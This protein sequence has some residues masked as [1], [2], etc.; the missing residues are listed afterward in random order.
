MSYVYSASL[1]AI[2]TVTA[3]ESISLLQ[4]KEGE[5]QLD[6][7][8]E[9]THLLR[10]ILD[11]SEYVETTSDM[12]SPVVHYRLTRNALSMSNL[13]NIEEQERFLQEI[14]DEVA[15]PP[16]PNVSFAPFELC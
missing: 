1:P 15:S 6:L 7:L 16:P 14:V 2:L 13:S 11:K 3:S 12:S 8:Q 10:S 4:T 5:D 9:N